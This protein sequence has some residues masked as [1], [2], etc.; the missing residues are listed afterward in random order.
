MKKIIYAILP[1][2]AAATNVGAAEAVDNVT[3]DAVEIAREGNHLAVSMNIG[4]DRLKVQ[5]GR[6][7][8]LTPWIVKGND[9]I[10]LAPVRIYGRS[11]YIY[12]MR[13]A[14][15]SGFDEKD[16]LAYK[17]SECP[18]QIGYRQF[19]PYSEWMD[20]ATLRLQRTDRGCCRTPLLNENAAI[21]KYSEEFFPPLLYV[22]PQGQR[23]KR[24]SL[25]GKAYIDFPVD[26]TVIYPDYRRNTAELARIRATID[27]IRDDKDARIDTVWLKG[28]A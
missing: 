28:F 12:E 8:T 16:P 2:L 22:K 13:N 17:A 18:A 20:G 11:R 6:G 15:Q 1:M 5:S 7:V 9:S 4:L 10:A 3:V 21:G 24:R 23:E 26:Q 27:T 25:E 14:A 19:I